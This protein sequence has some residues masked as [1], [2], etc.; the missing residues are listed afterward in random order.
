[1]KIKRTECKKQNRNYISKYNIE[2]RFIKITYGY[3]LN[4]FWFFSK[5]KFYFKKVEYFLKYSTLQ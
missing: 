5:I 1:M 4:N 2:L 3:G